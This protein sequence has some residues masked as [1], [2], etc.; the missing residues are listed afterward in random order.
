MTDPIGIRSLSERTGVS[1]HT[2]RYYE[3]AGLMLP[4]AR[5]QSGRRVYSE[6]HVRWVLFLRRLRAGGM[7]IAP[8]RE[9]AELTQRDSDDARRRRTILLSRHRDEVRDR[10]RMLSDHLAVL[11][12]KVERGCSPIHTDDDRSTP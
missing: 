2:L 10:I 11:D 1:A 7:G 12:R 4:V 9:Y 5:D 8:L 6:E 3:R